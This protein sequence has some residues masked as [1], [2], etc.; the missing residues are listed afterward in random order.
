MERFSEFFINHWDLF[1][2]LA[3]ILFMMFSGPLMQRLRGFNGIDPSGAVLLINHQD[4]L[5]ID[6]REESELKDGVILDSIHIPV[7]QFGSRIEELDEHKER[8]IIVGCRSGARSSGACGKLK[9]RGFEQVY[10]LTGGMM[11]WQSA[12][13][14]LDKGNKRKKKKKS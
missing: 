10:N 13:L 12:G 3:F 7:G 4:A 1:A 14:P 9:S 6:V 11:A 8:P 2:V 5:C